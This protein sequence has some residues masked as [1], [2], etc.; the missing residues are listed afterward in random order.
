M[1]S[2][3]IVRK[4]DELGRVVIPIELRRTLEIAEKDALEIYVDGEQIILKKYA[5][6]CI[7][8]GQAKDVVVFKNKNICPACLEELQK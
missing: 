6:A 2:T 3:G 1:K 7:F 4:V 5:P 8:C